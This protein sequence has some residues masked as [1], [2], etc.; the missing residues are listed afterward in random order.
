MCVARIFNREETLARIFLATK[1]ANFT[2]MKETLESMQKA[3]EQIW[4]GAYVITTHGLKMSKLDYCMAVLEEA[5]RVLPVPQSTE[6]RYPICAGYHHWIMK[7]D[8]FGSFLAAQ[9]V[10]DLKNTE[11]H[12]L[13]KA[14]DWFYFS[15][16]GPGSLR[17]LSWW[18]GRPI[19]E[20]N[21]QEAIYAVYDDLFK[22]GITDIHFQDLQNCLC[23]FDKYC[24]VLSGTGKSKRNYP[25]SGPKEAQGAAY[26]RTFA[27]PPT[28]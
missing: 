2:W 4:S 20:R 27:T 10:A 26:R 19:S 1:D 21:Y 22:R 8:G 13:Q 12:P 14:E 23:E 18:H 16:P 25:G 28:T 7:I 11:G 15:A 6:G 17:G 3:G 24:R 5:K 9:V